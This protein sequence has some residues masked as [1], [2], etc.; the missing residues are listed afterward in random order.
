M[1]PTTAPCCFGFLLAC[2]LFGSSSSQS[3]EWT[4]SV[5]FARCAALAC[6]R[7]RSARTERSGTT[8]HPGCVLFSPQ[9]CCFLFVCLFFYAW[10]KCIKARLMNAGI[11][12]SCQR[13]GT[14]GNH[15][16]AEA[17]RCDIDTQ[18]LFGRLYQEA[19][20]YL[21]E[22]LCPLRAQSGTVENL[23]GECS[24]SITR[25]LWT[26][27][28]QTQTSDSLALQQ[29]TVPMS[30]LLWIDRLSDAR[31]SSEKFPSWN[32]SLSLQTSLF[33]NTDSEEEGDQ[34]W[35]PRRFFSHWKC[36]FAGTAGCIYFCA[37]HFVAPRA[38][39]WSRK[40]EAVVVVFQH[41]S[42]VQLFHLNKRANI[43]PYASCYRDLK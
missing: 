41:S 39:I 5:R 36:R 28:G 24:M 11:T 7:S 16:W 33:L 3:G 31:L 9:C 42:S 30:P 21:W 14:E 34:L 27:C 29:A 40:A 23:E 12:L 15:T 20:L 35:P 6:P 26:Q 17:R 8:I 10:N 1:K 25:V 2:L 32:C 13:P 18:V 4:P 43:G 37:S 22:R 38:P 19:F